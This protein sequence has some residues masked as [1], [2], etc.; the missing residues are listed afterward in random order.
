MKAKVLYLKEELNK[1][2]LLEY[3]I[4]LENRIINKIKRIE[5]VEEN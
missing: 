2:S 3:P 4:T 5:E 1:K